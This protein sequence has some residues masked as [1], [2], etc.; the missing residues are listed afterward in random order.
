MEDDKIQ[1]IIARCSAVRENLK[2]IVQDLETYRAYL[3]TTQSKQRGSNAKDQ[4]E[5]RGAG[6]G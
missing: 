3:R 5:E 6:G 2:K 4:H 1:E